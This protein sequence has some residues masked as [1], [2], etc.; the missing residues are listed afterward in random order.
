[1]APGDVRRAAVLGKPIS[2]SLS[3]ALHRAAYRALGLDWTYDAIELDAAGLPAFVAGL[4]ATWAGLSLTMP[5]K[6]AV[7]PL[8]DSISELAGLVG[9]VNT[10][11]PR[12]GRLVGENTDIY[13]M[14]QAICE[15]Q[16]GTQPSFPRGV[17]G[18]VAERSS[19]ASVGH[20]AFPG[21]QTPA[22]VLSLARITATTSPTG[23]AHGPIGERALLLG[24]GATARSALAAL[25]QM[26]VSQV[27]VSAR[28]PQAA[29][30]LEP[31][32][33]QLGLAIVPQLWLAATPGG[34]RAWGE[35][36]GWL[37][38]GGVISTLPAAAWSALPTVPATLGPVGWLLDVSYA[39][40]P[41][42]LVTAWRE[43]GG[44]AAS[45]LTMLLW[46]AVEQVRLMTGR[47]VD[48]GVVAAMRAALPS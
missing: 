33:S 40:D 32:A 18:P 30:G 24:G 47:T 9:T 39:P 38:G 45:G 42:P 26:G 10:V 35:L 1:M 41:P 6:T 25:A 16:A 31:L 15:L 11:L 43:A 23:Q 27:G 34:G 44:V 7:I 20:A 28:R 46:Q 8:L 4:D 17:P 5:C 14:V 19:G 37:R 48:A 12:H 3:P 29:A 36:L 2:H 22:S 13:G 21:S